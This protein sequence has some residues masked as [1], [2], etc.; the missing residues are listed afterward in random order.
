MHTP[1]VKVGCVKHSQPPG[2]NELWRCSTRE[3]HSLR[4]L[5]IACE[6]PYSYGAHAL[7]PLMDLSMLAVTAVFSFQLV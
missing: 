5:G 2:G 6:K 3:D 7:G 1:G 4:Y